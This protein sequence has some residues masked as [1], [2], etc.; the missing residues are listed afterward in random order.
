MKTIKM[1]EDGKA[2][3]GYRYENLEALKNKHS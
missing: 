2:I 1:T 3:I